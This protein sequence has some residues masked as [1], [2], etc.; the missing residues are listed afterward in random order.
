MYKIS[1]A[2]TTY[3][4]ARFIAQQL[5]S[6]LN[7]ERQAD[8]VVI[9]DDH[10]TDL[11]A[12]IVQSFIDSHQLNASW[13]LYINAKNV[14]FKQNFFNA[15]SASTG[16]LIFLCDQ[17]DLWDAGKLQT[18]EQV[19]LRNDRIMALCSSF[20]IIDQANGIMPM[21]SKKKYA[22]NNLFR[23]NQVLQVGDIVK[24]KFVQACNNNISPGCTMGFRS[25]IKSVYLKNTSLT[26][27]HDWE[28]SFIAACMD[29]LYYLNQPLISYRVH[30]N[31]TIGLDQVMH[32]PSAIER[33][34]GDR[35][36]RAAYLASHVRAF[37]QYNNMIDKG[38]RRI[39][40]DELV[41]AETRERALASKSL[42]LLLK[43]YHYNRYYRIGT[44]LAGKLSDIIFILLPD[45]SKPT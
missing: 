16:D 36:E 39:L 32:E 17:D 37:Q 4:G 24:I 6:L 21:K 25:L 27:E 5:L 11:T 35:Q 41:F 22:N 15:I 13:K 38:K 40:S 18:M 43:L 20:R 2:M 26:I 8:D 42:K 1:I 44:S 19:F 14:G 10:S 30:T 31:N 12:S 29:G 33:I 23:I 3:N 34:V 28:L 9:Y 7:Q 45:S